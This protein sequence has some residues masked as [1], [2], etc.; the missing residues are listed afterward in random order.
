MNRMSRLPLT[1]ASALNRP[2]AAT[3]LGFL[4]IVLSGA[5]IPLSRHLTEQLGTFTT[6]AVVYLGA[7]L[8]GCAPLLFAS[9]RRAFHQLPRKYMLVC[10][11]LL[12]LYTLLLYLAMGYPIPSTLLEAGFLI[13]FPTLLAYVFWDHA[14]RFGHPA[15]LATASYFMP[16]LAMLAGALVL[17]LAI[18][19]SQWLACGLVIIG[20]LLCRRA[21][22][23]RTQQQKAE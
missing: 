18:N 21:L 16:V 12:V 6:A 4:A 14:F 3:A 11:L 13:V 5:T 9:R 22:F 2:A 19:P 20:S 17:K 15:F 7:G 10:G 23:S 1:L 8:I